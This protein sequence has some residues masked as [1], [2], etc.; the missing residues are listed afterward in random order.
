MA[1]QTSAQIE[2]PP[3]GNYKDNYLPYRKAEDNI[4]PLLEAINPLYTTAAATME[5]TRHALKRMIPDDGEVRSV[6]R[7]RLPPLTSA[8][9]TEFYDISGSIARTPAM[10]TPPATASLSVVIPQPVLTKDDHRNIKFRQAA[11]LRWKP[12]LR[13][14]FPKRREITEAYN[15]KLMRHYKRSNKLPEPNFIK[16]R[17]DTSPRVMKLLRQFPAAG[18]PIMGRQRLEAGNPPGTYAT[19][20]QIS[21]LEQD[22]GNL[23]M[24]KRITSSEYGRQLAWQSF[25]A[26]ERDRIDNGRRALIE[27]GLV[28]EDLIKERQGVKNGLPEWKKQFT[29][30][31]AA[32]RKAQQQ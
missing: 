31:Y 5:P 4:P 3:L 23:Q 12:R 2:P 17:I 19:T 20:A 29:G 9:K 11:A 7:Q 26:T 27:S 32:G 28:A 10:I 6:K 15:L 25:S 14:P 13:K 1:S 24:N 30:K 22:A 21:Q 16:P 8:T 18:L